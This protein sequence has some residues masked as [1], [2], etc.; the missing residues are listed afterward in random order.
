[1]DLSTSYLGL[2]LSH[3]FM[4]G[5]SPLTQDL[6]L[7]RRLEDAGASAVVMH[8]L[9]EEEIEGV[10]DV[11]RPAPGSA[12]GAAGAADPH[13][14]LEQIRRIRAAVTVPVIASLNGTSAGG[15]L[16]WA[17]LLEDAGAS[18]LELNVYEIATDPRET[19]ADVERRIFEIVRSVAEEVR[20]PVAVKLSPFFSA[21]AHF[22]GR[23]DAAGARGLVLF[24][25]FYQ[26]DL[27]IEGRTV[28][29][30]L[31][32]SDPQELPL[33][34]RWLAI[35]S[36]RVNASLAVTGGVHEP[37]DAVKAILAGAHVVQMVS[38]LLTSG[39]ERLRT[40]REGVT[41]WL[42]EHGLDA[43]DAVR[44]TM[45]LRRAGD[46]KAYER[47]NYLRVL[48]EWRAEP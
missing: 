48:Q 16:A 13:E 34:L 10:F 24:N 37:S 30:R 18:A 35:L 14:Y 5:A 43:L 42:G 1:V 9:F 32:F 25:R 39:P 36:E 2:S 7:V 15:W 46:P 29:H 38:A 17:S 21:L 45:N 40:V 4:N 23:M 11:R 20:I 28:T 44:G 3:P 8:S 33:R 31:R 26:P 47:G 22:A 19:G 41:R 27:D 6:D 12:T